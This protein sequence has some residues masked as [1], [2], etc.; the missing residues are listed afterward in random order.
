[1]KDVKPLLLYVLATNPEPM[2]AG[3]LADLA[4][5]ACD[6]A[7]WER[8]QWPELSAKGVS[9]LLQHM[10]RTGDVTRVGK[11]TVNGQPRDLWTAPA[12]PAAVMPAPE[13]CGRSATDIIELPSAQRAILLDVM[14]EA[15]EHGERQRLEVLRMVERQRN[16]HEAFVA[17]CRRRLI[18]AGLREQ[19]PELPA[20]VPA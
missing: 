8:N 1:V 6:E 11:D 2:T 15:L 16:E 12:D 13:S 7:G 20:P 17:R 5:A 18:N 3:T 19:L 4:L 14:Q 10:E 9:K